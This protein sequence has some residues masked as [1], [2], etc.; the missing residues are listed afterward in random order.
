MTWQAWTT[1]GA[2][3]LVLGLLGFTRAG[4]D[5]IFVGVATL[6]MALG[7]LSPADALS[8]LAN[9]GVI[10]VGVLYIVA[11]GLRETG[12][13]SVAA[14]RLL[15]RP[16]SVRHAQFRMMAPVAAMSAF[17]NNTP[18]VAMCLPVVNDWA[19]RHKLSPSKLMLP[20]SYAAIFGGCCTL[21]GTST[22]LVVHGLLLEHAHIKEPLHLFSLAWVGV[23]C[24]LVG[25]GYILLCSGALLPDRRAAARDFEDPKQYTVEM[26][27]ESGSTLA[28]KTIEGAGLRQLPGMYLMEIDRDGEILAAVGPLERLQAGD[29]LVFV[30][31]VESV[32][33]L[34]KIRGLKPAT[35]QVFKLDSP[36]A[37]RS[38]IEAV[39]SD[40]C[41]LVG[42]TVRDGRFRTIYNAAIIAVS[43]NGERI[44]KKVGDI[45]LKP[46]DTLLLESHPTFAEQHRNSRD[47]YLVSRIEGYTPPRHE[48]AWL[49]GA[50]FV[51][52]IVAAGSGKTS[53]L[54]AAM[55]AAGLMIIGRCC[56][57]SVARA[58]V[59]W[60]VLIAI[61]ASF[62]IGRAMES[63]G[64]A[65]YIAESMLGI[66]GDNRWA[67]LAVVYVLAMICTELMSNNASAV[68]MFPIAM[69]TATALHADFMPFVMAVM[70]AASFGFATPLG[71]QTHLMVYGP[72]GYRFSDF[73]RMG[74]PLDLLMGVI[75]VV[76]IPRFW[77][78]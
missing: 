52:M 76:L 33:E 19:K 61:A 31:I 56:T 18:I 37:R 29:R 41:P 43:R 34:Q 45:I 39:V 71:Y 22:N 49:S 69:A 9:E 77:P 6:L 35:D 23:P 72:G 8:G 48:R 7:I 50:I 16:K 30:G 21:I 55:L 57:S 27:V 67:A 11:A 40:S 62:G 24:A 78:F 3:L 5:L 42:K 75:A 51:A 73:L 2:V 13:L 63:T 64:A 70:F 1:I 46:G 17:V 47:F 20:L 14:Q 54:L 4:A 28:G 58:S 36:R 44:R 38:L 53:M 15:G 25:I 32:V 12:V 60:Q 26:I 10:T 74:I 68:L 66:A 65:R 59:D